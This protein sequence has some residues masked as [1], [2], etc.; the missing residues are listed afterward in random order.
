MNTYHKIQT[1][2][3]R[4]PETKYKTLLEGD[5]SRPEFEFLKDNKWVFTEKVDGTNIRVMFA[6]DEITFGGKTDR[7]QLHMELVQRL[8]DTFLPK[9]DEFR[10]TFRPKDGEEKV[11]V[12]MYGEGYGPGIQ[13]VG[14]LYRKDKDFVLFDIK[15]GAW[16]LQR[17][18]VEDIAFNMGVDIAPQ[19]GSGT[20]H[21]MVDMVRGGITSAWGDFQA[22]G[23]VARPEV[24]LKARNGQR[25][26]TKLKCKDFKYEG[27]AG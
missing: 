23:I 14:G 11:G 9:L 2:Y 6:N 7:A 4:D 8:Q 22:E 24:E 5:Y 21:D 27:N 25:I 18:D 3:K 16:W 13:K 20:L 10:E 17:E 19:I 1:V 15:I 12:C 26:I